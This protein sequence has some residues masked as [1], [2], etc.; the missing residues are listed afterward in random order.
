MQWCA[1]WSKDGA[2]LLLLLLLLVVRA[3]GHRCPTQTRQDNIQTRPGCHTTTPLCCCCCQQSALRPPS[4]SVMPRG[5]RVQH[6]RLCCCCCW[7]PIHF[8]RLR[9]P[10]P[11]RARVG[12]PWSSFVRAEDQ[13]ET[14]GLARPAFAVRPFARMLQVIKEVVRWGTRAGERSGWSPEERRGDGP[15]EIRVG[16]SCGG[17]LC[18]GR[19]DRGHA[20]KVTLTGIRRR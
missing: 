14:R 15:W 10:A 19:R 9:G 7:W 17:C 5:R 20:G 18:A 2:R 16:G 12:A 6:L 1:A 8:A 13:H 3:G 11:V 4:G